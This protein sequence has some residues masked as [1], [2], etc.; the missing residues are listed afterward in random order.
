[1][2]LNLFCSVIKP[3]QM[4]YCVVVNTRRNYDSLCEARSDL[5]EVLSSGLTRRLIGDEVTDDRQ[6]SL[7]NY[8]DIKVCTTGK[9]MQIC[10]LQ[11]IIISSSMVVS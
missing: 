1:M 9:Y 11:L 8:N 2:I 6:T 4:H 10:A 5:N 7:Q 3:Q